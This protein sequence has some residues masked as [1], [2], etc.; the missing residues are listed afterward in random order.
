[1]PEKTCR[2]V[3][4]GCKVN[5]YE[6]QLVKEALLRNGYREARDGEAAGLCVV[7]TCTVTAEGDAKS[8][9]TVRQLARRNPGTRT[10]VMGCY[11]TRDPGAVAALPG[12]F[13]VVSD[14][15][16]LPDVFDRLGVTEIPT[17]IS[18]FRRPPPGLR[19]GAGRLHP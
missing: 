8:R 5:Q 18:A 14:K 16:E 12:V 9:Q 17:G 6:T 7:N 4:L 13:E 1:M 3:T 10:V 15:R 2:L 19:Q 11:A